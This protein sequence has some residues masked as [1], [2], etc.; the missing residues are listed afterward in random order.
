[1]KTA[2]AA[3]FCALALLS[4][5]LVLPGIGEAQLP[6]PTVEFI[7]DRVS[8]ESSFVMIG[9]P[10]VTGKSIRMTWVLDSYGS[11]PYMNGK[12]MCYFSDT[13]HESTCGPSPFRFITTESLDIKSFD[14]EGNWANSTKLVDVG[15]I[16]IIPDVEFDVNN[17][18]AL[19]T[20]YGGI[21]L[22]APVKSITYRVYDSSF[23]P[24]SGNYQSMSKFL[25][26]PY[27]N[28]SVPLTSDVQYVAFKAASDDDFGGGIIRISLTDGS[29]SGGVTGLLT[30]DPVNIDI[31]YQPG[32]DPALPEN[33]R[34][35]NSNNQNFTGVTID[36]PSSISQYLSIN[37]LSSYNGTI[38]PNEAVYYEMKLTR[39]DSSIELLGDAVIKSKTGTRLGVIPIDIRISYVGGGSVNCDTATEGALCLG[40]KCCGG[41]CRQGADCCTTLDC[42]TGTCSSSYE[43]SSSSTSISCTTG[44]CRS[45]L[46]SC[47]SGYEE[48]GT[49]TQSGSTGPCCLEENECLGQL[50]GFSCSLGVCE[51]DRC[52]MC[53]IDGD[54]EDD[55]Y[56]SQSI[57]F[58]EDGPTPP[59]GGDMTLIIIIIV[60]VVAA[61]GAGAYYYFTQM[62]K[63][64]SAEEDFEKGKEEDEAFDD[65]EFY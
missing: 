9:D 18:K 46:I 5:I 16:K 27:Y 49:C 56:C 45:D 62:K 28:T 44:T 34:I 17:N 19:I 7:P 31:V 29:G 12:Y 13:D 50:D 32:L 15:G 26:T 30:A 43:C 39:I 6:A 54:C 8:A 41:I 57:C 2:S 40:G 25:G 42:T 21:T 1:M 14:S 22:D 23:N 61:G 24:V 11:M 4:V 37:L 63:P 35:I 33:K 64:K 52:V 38:G 58:E 60:A 51:D 65:D 53:I 55:E 20:A 36:V 59:E 48:T 47:P 10:G 3:A